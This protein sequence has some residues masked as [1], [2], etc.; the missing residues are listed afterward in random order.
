MF[1]SRDNSEPS[2]CL[3]EDGVD[4]FERTVRGFGVEEVDDGE[5]ESVDDGEDDVGLVA[6]GGKRDGCDHHDLKIQVLALL[7]EK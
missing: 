6:D 7:L 2:F 1:G 3:A 5:D 4:F